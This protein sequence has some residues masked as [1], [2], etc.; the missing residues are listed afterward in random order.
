MSDVT[1]SIC[2]T[3]LFVVFVSAEQTIIT[4]ESGDEV[5][6]TC[7][8]PNNN[9][10]RVVDWNR[11]D[12]GDKHVLFY[13]DGSFDQDNQHPS[14][15]NRVVLQDIQ[16]KDGDV[17]LILKDV[18][19]KDAG[20]Y[21]CIVLMEGEIF[22]T[23][24]SSITMIVDPPDQKFIRTTSG[25]DVTLTCRAPTNKIRR[26]VWRRTE[27]PGFVLLSQDGQIDPDNQHPSFK[28]RV[29]LQDRQMKDG[30]VSLILKDVTIDDTG[31]YECGVYMEE[32]RSW[33]SI[34][35]IYLTVVDPPEQTIITA[36]S[37]DEVTLT[38]RAPNNNKIRV[39]DWN[40]D[41]LGDKHVLFYRDGSFD[42][43][44][45]HPSFKNRVDLQ[46]RQMKDGDVSLILKDVTIKDTG[47]YVC[48]VYM[49]ERHSWKVISSI[50]LR[51]LPPDPKILKSEPGA[52]VT[53]TCRAANNN[54]RV[55]K[56]SRD[57]MPEYVLLYQHG[58]LDSTNQH[59]SFKNRVDLQYRQMKDGDV[60]LI[61]RN[62]T[63]DDTGTY[64][65]RV[66]MS[67]TR[68]WKVISSIY[69]I[70]DPPGTLGGY[71]AQMVDL[72]VCLGIFLLLLLLF[73]TLKKIQNHWI[74]QRRKRRKQCRKL[75]S[76]SPLHH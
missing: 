69:L 3:L 57:L 67:E 51:V 41:D 53:L 61:L 64:K 49:E 16:M 21:L 31:T 74:I 10:I 38:C 50:Y 32:T 45:Q 37:G 24:I 15:K 20:R 66:F 6:L 34:S 72:I 71:E 11:D 27:K 42:R 58:R 5:T 63:T 14:F 39:V 55:L 46:D 43:D 48:A 18:T 9:K 76:K 30:D 12:L 8:A 19:I 13:R 52:E 44:D 62:V 28:N 59:P 33:K 26:V 1:A 7:R 47:R 73:L 35:I 4:A 54:I 68:S 70:V 17:S 40:R 56:W 29:D 22:W 75:K 25:Q 65:C 23:P 36:E 60:S 2:W